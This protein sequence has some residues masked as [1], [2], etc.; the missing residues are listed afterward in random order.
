MH[1][2]SPEVKDELQKRLRRIEGQVRGVQKML[3][4]ERDCRDIIQQLTAVR[5]AVQQA[6]IQFLRHYAKECLLDSADLSEGVRTELIDDL[7][8]YMG[9]VE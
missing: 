9:K 5:S 3:D 6:R 2:Q 8:S 7:I 4:D 1:I